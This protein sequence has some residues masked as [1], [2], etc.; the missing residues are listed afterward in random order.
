[1]LTSVSVESCI[2]YCIFFLSSL[3][4]YLPFRAAHSPFSTLWNV[5]FCAVRVGLS[6]PWRWEANGFV[7]E[8][9]RDGF[10]HQSGSVSRMYSV[11]E[12]ILLKCRLHFEKTATAVLNVNTST[13]SGAWQMR[14][15]SYQSVEC[16]QHMPRAANSSSEVLSGWELGCL[17]CSMVFSVF[18]VGLNTSW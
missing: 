11:A 5:Q 7:V 3:S 12:N 14:I 9:Q 4:L 1:M 18:A 2:V 16:E 10:L 8:P 15:D 13:T 17:S 6:A